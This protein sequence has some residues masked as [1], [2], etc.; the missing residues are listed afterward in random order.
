MWGARIC[1]GWGGLM[2]IAVE[3]CSSPQ[4]SR[5]ALRY[6]VSGGGMPQ[7]D[8]ISRLLVAGVPSHLAW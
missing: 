2:Q 4:A 1:S 5:L 8:F 3:S 7:H 6:R